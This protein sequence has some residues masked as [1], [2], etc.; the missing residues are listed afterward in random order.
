M[1]NHNRMRQFL[2]LAL[3]VF[4]SF[5][6]LLFSS[7]N[8]TSS[9]LQVVMWG[10]ADGTVFKSSVK[11][12]ENATNQYQD[13]EAQKEK[14]V[15]LVNGEIEKVYYV[16]S[17]KKGQEELAV[18]SSKNGNITCSYDRETNKLIK[19]SAKNNAIIVPDNVKSEVDYKA[20]VEGVLALYGVEDLSDYRYSCKTAVVVS[21]ENST[22][23]ETHAYF[24]SDQKANERIS[25]LEFSYTKY[26]EDYPT[27]DRIEVSVLTSGSIIVKFDEHRFDDSVYISFD[28]SD[29]H[30]AVESFVSSSINAGEYKYDTI[31][32]TNKVLTHYDTEVCMQVY[33]EINMLNRGDHTPVTTMVT[34]LVFEK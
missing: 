28:E 23:K 14:N 22:Y 31:N 13:E 9:S 18:Y 16:E 7:C 24:Y 25:S 2:G 6:T 11:S 32:I 8:N 1:Y 3:V 34:L 5:S 27:T 33:V 29:I 26:I 17:H 4:V 12:V 21:N 15:T 10:Q 20:W 30:T 19:L